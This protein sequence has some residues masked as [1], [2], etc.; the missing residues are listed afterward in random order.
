MIRKLTPAPAA[1][2]I[3]VLLSLSTANAD[4]IFSTG[5]DGT[6]LLTINSQTGV[7]T[8]VGT[9]GI[10]GAVGL[11]FSPDGTLYTVANSYPPGAANVTLEQLATVNPL[12]GVATLVGTPFPS[13]AGIM[14]MVVSSS[15]TI[16]AAGTSPGSLSNKLLTINPVTGQL[17]VVGAFGGTPNIMDFAYDLN[18]TL[19]GASTTKLYTINASTG[20]ATFVI[21]FTGVSGVM[22][23]TFDSAGNLLA[24]NFS[25]TSSLY[26]VNIDTG[27]ATL[28][29]Q[30][31]VP[32]V[33]S[34]D[35]QP[36]PEPGSLLLLGS[37]LAGFAGVL[38][39]KLYW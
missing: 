1:L 8:L 19:Y 14:P 17:T 16:F 37:G 10:S 22:G 26:N 9:L 39:R 21:S 32:D 29:G 4:T 34:A 11:T 23:I 31:G 18:G 12:T 5:Q 25:A 36:V 38:R 28:I 30:T 33:H 2:L 35:M 15:G 13:R 7:A 24:T 20:T 6:K 3:F 27:V